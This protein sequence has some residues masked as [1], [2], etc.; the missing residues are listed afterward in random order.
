MGASR[1]RVKVRRSNSILAN[2]TIETIEE[3]MSSTG[4]KE[5]IE[6][7]Q[8][9]PI[10]AEALVG[11][12]QPKNGEKNKFPGG[13]TAEE[14]RT[15]VLPKK[16]SLV[17][18]LLYRR[19]LVAF[20]GRR[21]SGKTSIL[22]QLALSLTMWGSEAFLGYDIPKQR[23]VLIYLLEDDSRE[24]QDRLNR[25]LNAW[26]D[27]GD[28]EG[29]LIIR[30]KDDF[31]RNDVPIGIANAKFR[32]VIEQDCKDHNPDLI[33]FDNLGFLVGADYN[34][35]RTIHEYIGFVIGLSQEYDCAIITAA[36]PR[37]QGG[38]KEAVTLEKDRD[39]FFEEVMGSSHFVNSCGSLWGI[40]RTKEGFSHFYAGTQRLSGSAHPMAVEMDDD[41]WLCISDNFDVNF[42]LQVHTDQRKKTWEALP[43]TFTYSEARNATK[44]IL[45]SK[46]AFTPF[47]NGLKRLK[48][49]VPVDS[50]EE[51]RFR[52]AQ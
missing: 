49:I 6:V 44:N 26:Q 46:N 31:Y 40:E 5:Q 2:K 43:T 45:K 22:L 50:G 17:E 14:F 38:G 36:H 24:L 25:V 28:T 48:L 13:K 8:Q 35:S 42:K 30:T 52:K 12:P 19:D 20:A 1:L 9:N 7:E 4:S 10:Q 27:A 32:E 16:E 11:T 39:M 18:G 3:T 15:M 37:K 29:R 47:W 41:G 21:R 33:I 51:E 23:K 34:D